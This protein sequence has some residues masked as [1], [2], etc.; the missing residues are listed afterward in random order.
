MHQGERSVGAPFHQG[1]RLDHDLLLACSKGAL[2][3]FT[4]WT[5][6]SGFPVCSLLHCGDLAMATW[7]VR[8][9][10]DME[11]ML[12]KRFFTFLCRHAEEFL[13]LRR[14]PIPVRPWVD[15]GPC[16]LTSPL[17]LVS[18]A[19]FAL[20]S[21]SYQSCGKRQIPVRSGVH[22]ALI[23]LMSG[24]RVHCTCFLSPL[25]HTKCPLS[26]SIPPVRVPVGLH[27]N[28]RPWY[29]SCRNAAR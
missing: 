6:Q 14:K 21:V 26:S 25:P 1:V 28:H 17:H 16:L 19:S 8:Q 4:E 2:A 18:C 23:S 12:A 5:V 13:I 3:A 22:T 10:D 27:A 15:T 9:S 11:R 29:P 7:Q 20:P 24:L